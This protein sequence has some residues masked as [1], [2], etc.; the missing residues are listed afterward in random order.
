ML[1]LAIPFMFL[2]QLL[3]GFWCPLTQMNGVPVGD[4][5]YFNN[6]LILIITGDLLNYYYLVNSNNLVTLRV[7]CQWT[8]RSDHH[9]CLS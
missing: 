6:V 3:Q 9:S 8:L 4:L 5:C 7:A 1:V 2:Y